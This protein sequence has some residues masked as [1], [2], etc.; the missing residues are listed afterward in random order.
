MSDKYEV[1]TAANHYISQLYHEAVRNK[2]DIDT[3]LRKIELS[4]ELVDKPEVRVKTEKLAALQNLVWRELQDESMGL[5]SDPVPAGSY[6]MMGRLTVNQ[7][8]LRKA[9]ELAARFYSIVTSAFK[10]SLS[11]EQ[12]TAFLRF[13]LTSPESDPHHMFAELM[14][15]AMHRYA[16]WL[17]ADSL[18]LIETHFH[19]SP[20]GHIAEYSYLFPG[21]HIFDS[22]KLGF[23][24]PASYLQRNVQQNDA[25][26]KLFMQRCPQEI[27]Q[28]YEADYSLTTELKRL[29][30]K[31]LKGGV[32]SIEQA[33]IKMN[34]TKR[35]LMRKLKA[36]G[37][38]YQQLKDVVR[39]D[40]ALS[41]LTKYSLPINKISESVGFSEPAVF[42]RAFL[43]WTGESPSQYR[44]RNSKNM[45]KNQ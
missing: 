45:Q 9:L 7:T 13:E 30:W 41:L 4:A 6:F 22:T 42:T 5:T 32:P 23:A 1:G 21:V 34:M 25:S 2:L 11:V 33:A 38:S 27:F 17:I 10:M 37:T 16:S 40:K 31:N 12:E 44:A 8:T 18:P 3:M 28:R 19:Y 43:H 36:E 14:L 35:T 24:I 29:L 20:P 26:L 39:L 15:M